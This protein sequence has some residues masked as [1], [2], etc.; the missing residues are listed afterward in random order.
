[1]RGSQDPFTLEIYI[2]ENSTVPIFTYDGSAGL[3]DDE[4][5]PCVYYEKPS[6]IVTFSAGE[7]VESI[8]MRAEKK[9][10]KKEDGVYI[11]K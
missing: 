8:S 2:D 6:N 3:A 7:C 1:M 5:T 4:T 10:K 11:G 9:V